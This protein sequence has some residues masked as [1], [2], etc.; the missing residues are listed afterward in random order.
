MFYGAALPI[1]DGQQPNFTTVVPSVNYTDVQHSGGIMAVAKK[2]TYFAMRITGA[3]ALPGRLLELS[4][5]GDRDNTA[6]NHNRGINLA[7]SEP[8]AAAI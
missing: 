2:T 8:M 6:V 3:E 4:R 7:A 5:A 1:P